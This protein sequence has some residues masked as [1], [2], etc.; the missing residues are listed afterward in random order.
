[1]ASIRRITIENPL[2]AQE[3][4]LREDVLLR[5]IGYDMARYKRDFAGME[6]RLEHFVA[7]VRQ[8]GGD[9]VVGCAALLPH[10]PREGSGRLTQMAVDRQRQGEGIGRRLVVAV[11]SRAFG[12]LGLSDLHCHSQVSAMGFFQSLGWNADSE[13]F[14]EAGLPHRRMA[15]R[16]EAAEDD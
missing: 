4:A 5:P 3:C 7:V 6:E 1:V 2:Y 8:P 10:D 16:N 9:R 13:V 15:I 12:E 14:T 11:E